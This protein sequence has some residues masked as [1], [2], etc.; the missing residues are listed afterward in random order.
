MYC[1]DATGGA[2][3]NNY[4]GDCNV[5]ARAVSGDTTQ[6]D[7]TPS[8]GSDHYALLTD[9]PND[10][11]ST[12]VSSSTSGDEDLY[13]VPALG[14]TP[15]KIYGVGVNVIA[16]KD[17]TGTRAVAPVMKSGSTYLVGGYA[18]LSTSYTAT[19][20]YATTDPATGV[21]WTLSGANAITPGVRVI[22]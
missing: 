22:T 16:R 15:T 6:H 5:I 17:D 11:D 1:L 2:P 13:S 10:G 9:C 8:A 14:F 3:F 18:Y 4:L 12:Y 21:A 19:Q 20:M 7:W